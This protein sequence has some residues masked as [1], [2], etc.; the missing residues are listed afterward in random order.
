MAESAEAPVL[1]LHLNTIRDLFV[2]PDGDPF[3]P[4][5]SDV[6]GVDELV[7][8]LT[9]K[10]HKSDL[11]ITI[12]L[13][14]DQITPGLEAQTRAALS[15]YLERRA[16]S[17]HNDVLSMR[18]GGVQAFFY[19]LGLSLLFAVPMILAY[20]LGWPSI[21]Q[22]LTYAAFIVIAW[23]A[24]WCA[25]EYILFDWLADARQARVL[26]A[27]REGELRILAEPATTG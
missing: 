2:A 16:R 6:S 7:N 19:A 11:R 15:R 8:Q 26:T 9:P 27:I 23:M 12:Y 25:V 22:A 18:R 10:R 13:P 1:E 24:M 20:S 5:F 17:A 14:A 3:D 21:I 4:N